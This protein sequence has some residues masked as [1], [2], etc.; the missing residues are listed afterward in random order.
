MSIPNVVYVFCCPLCEKVFEHD[1]PGEPCCTGPS[2][3]RDE[4]E[5]TLMHLVRIAHKE[6]GP[7]YAQARAE[8]QLLIIDGVGCN[9]RIQHEIMLATQRRNG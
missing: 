8:G 6:V 5:M 2:E 3:S 7:K 1:E 4:H 9:E